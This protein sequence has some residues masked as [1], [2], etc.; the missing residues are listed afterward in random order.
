MKSRNEV[1]RAHSRTFFGK[2]EKRRNFRFECKR[3]VDERV[4]RDKSG[5]RKA[6]VGEDEKK[7]RK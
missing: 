4:T 6:E 1:K 2:R 3:S 5:Q 7:R